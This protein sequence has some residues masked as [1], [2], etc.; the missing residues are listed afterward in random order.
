LQPPI[1]VTV[2]RATFREV[3]YIA[4]DKTFSRTLPHWQF[5]ADVQPVTGNKKPR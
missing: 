2:T 4:V 3:S 1:E 5:L